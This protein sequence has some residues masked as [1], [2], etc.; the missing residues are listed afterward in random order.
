MEQGAPEDV[1]S[2][3][4]EFMPEQTSGGIVVEKCACIEGTTYIEDGLE[5]KRQHNQ[6]YSM[7]VRVLTPMSK[8]S[9]FCQLLSV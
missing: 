1:D 7:T 6:R 9:E 5:R 3:D 2:L 4:R 8:G